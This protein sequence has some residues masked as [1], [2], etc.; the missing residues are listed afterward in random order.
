MKTNVKPKNHLTQ[1][2][3][4]CFGFVL[5]ILLGTFLLMTP[6][7]SKSHTVTPFADSMFTALSAT[8][9]TGLVVVDTFTHWTLFGQLVI[10]TLIQ[11]GGLGF[12]T[13]GVAFSLVLRNRIGL[14]ARGLM[15]ESIN[16]AKIGGIIKLAKKILIGTLYIE[17]IGSIL[18]A[19]RF[20]FD[21]G[22][23][24]G[25]YYGIFHAIS[26]FCNG[27]FDL[28]GC[29]EPY[30]S[31]TAYVTDPFVNIVI[32]ALIIIGGIGFIV[33]D[34]ISVNKLHFK[35]Y[36]LHTKV[37]LTTTIFLLL[38][39]TVLF[40][41]TEYNNTMKGM[42]VGER[43]LASLF[44][45]TTARTAGFNTIDTASLTGASKVLTMMHMFIG[46]SP[47]STA[48]GIKTTTL[49]ILVVS[50][51]SGITNR[52]K[53]S[54]FKRRFEDDAIKKASTVFLLNLLLAVTA[55]FAIL[56]INNLPM[57]D[58][59]FEVFS[60]IGTVGMSTGITRSLNLASRIIIMLLMFCGRVGSLSFALTFL[61]KKKDP[62]V[63][64]PAEEISVG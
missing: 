17:G 37:V 27:G 52:H 45:A 51:W 49:F 30:S 9:V 6:A 50:L 25:I 60:A 18:L 33:W 29:N 56:A 8:C 4:I 61:Q 44:S 10:L 5:I 31:L 58:I 7:A 23:L 21:M 36:R 2:R 54:I 63:Y 62:P 20:S 26:A 15:Q 16:S 48:G 41:I 59:F 38:S 11:I 1:T 55:C 64:Y 35:K 57:E 34:D 3:F 24:K 32:D 28:M 13:I 22:A 39:G 47:G 42:N 40:Y 19:I 46:G 12:I 14:K 53:T 43:I